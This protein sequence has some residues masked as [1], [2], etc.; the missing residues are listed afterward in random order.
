MNELQKT[1]FALLRRF[2]EICEKNGL[3]YY[4]VCGS[5]LGAVKYGGFI[6]WD[7][8]IDVALPRKDYETF[9]KTAPG[10][11]DGNMFLQTYKTDRYFPNFYAKLRNSDT[12]YIE[13]SVKNIDMNHGVC[14]DIF[15]LDGYPDDKTEQNKIERFKKSYSIKMST[16][17][18]TG[19]AS[20][21]VKAL[22][23]AEKLIHINNDRRKLIEK[24][25]DLFSSY[26][27]ETSAIWCNHGNWQ[28]ALEYAPREQYG[29]GSE[30]FFEGLKVRI[31]ELYDEYLTQKYGDWRADLPDEEKKGHHYF[32][33][34]DTKRSYKDYIEKTSQGRI[35]I[36]NKTPTDKA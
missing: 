22:A 5:C 15:P 18:D 36:V 2:V 35:R 20:P 34:C 32:A 23:F 31:P 27:T 8:D 4:L 30:A 33:V 14:I 28:G 10:L 21:K 19:S 11:L 29:K 25:N 12:A 7:D 6:P 26:P 1:E 17:F 3:E 24:A 16:A 9:C 13:N